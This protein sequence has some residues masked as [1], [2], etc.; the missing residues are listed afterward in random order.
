MAIIDVSIG[1]TFKVSFSDITF[2]I[3]QEKWNEL[4]IDDDLMDDYVQMH[5]M[6]DILNLGHSYVEVDSYDVP[7]NDEE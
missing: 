3:P 2:S 4:L 7:D 1:G 5:L 6:D